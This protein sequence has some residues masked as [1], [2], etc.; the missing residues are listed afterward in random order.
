MRLRTCPLQQ[1]VDWHAGHVGCGEPVRRNVSPREAPQR[2]TLHQHA[3]AP[4]AAAA[5]AAAAGERVDECR[6]GQGL[7]ARLV[8]PI[9]RRETLG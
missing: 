5:A 8:V 6:L 1:V 9:E 7:S 4:A 3:P 2:L